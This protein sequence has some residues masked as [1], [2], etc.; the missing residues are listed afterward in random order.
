MKSIEKY[1]NPVDTEVEEKLARLRELDDEDPDK[2]WEKV[3]KKEHI[4]IYKR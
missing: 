2:L 4:K 3:I 1:K